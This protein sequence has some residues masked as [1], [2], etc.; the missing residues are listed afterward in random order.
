ME[1]GTES[2]A[3]TIARAYFER[4]GA[5]DLDG[6]MEYWQPGGVGDIHGVAVLTA[7]TTY[8]EWFGDLFA[9]VPDLRFEVL[10]L[11]AEGDQ[12]AVRWRVTGTFDGDRRFNGLIPN[13]AGIDLTG[14]DLLTIRNGLIHRNEAYMNGVEMGQQLGIMPPQGSAAERALTGA[15]NLRTRLAQRLRRD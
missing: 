6:M 4:V 10:D 11:V 9:A 12:A 15:A 1:A 3:A 14:L 5:R 13:G 7:P 8:R 2:D